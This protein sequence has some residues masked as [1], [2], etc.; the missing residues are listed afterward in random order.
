MCD[1]SKVNFRCGHR[2]YIVRAWCKSYEVTHKNCPPKVKATEFRWDHRCGRC[3]QP[4]IHPNWV[5][6]IRMTP[7]KGRLVVAPIRPVI[8]IYDYL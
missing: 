3:R 1:Y 8:Y 4:S 6:R 7:F 2:R 5:V